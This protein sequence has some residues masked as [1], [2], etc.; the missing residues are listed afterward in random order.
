MLHKYDY[1][2]LIL[3]IKKSELYQTFYT[4]IARDLILIDVQTPSPALTP[5]TFGTDTLPGLT[6]FIK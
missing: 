6:W 5:F 3:L 2:Y 4:I 1:C